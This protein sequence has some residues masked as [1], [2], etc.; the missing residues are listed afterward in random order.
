[1]CICPSCKVNTHVTPNGINAS[2]DMTKLRFAWGVDCCYLGIFSYFIC[3]NPECHDVINKLNKTPRTN[4]DD[5][6][7]FQT[8]QTKKTT[9]YHFSAIDSRLTKELYPLAYQARLSVTYFDGRQGGMDTALASKL[10]RSKMDMKEMEDDLMTPLV[11][12]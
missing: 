2:N 12:T 8:R 4:I 11:S 5:D 1:M 6:S 3:A 10:F 9:G 7:M